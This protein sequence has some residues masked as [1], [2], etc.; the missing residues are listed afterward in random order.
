[1]YATRP[2]A[3]WIRTGS[4]PRKKRIPSG[5]RT[6]TEATKVRL[7]AVAYLPGTN[8]SNPIPSS[9]E[10]GLSQEVTRRGREARLSARVCGPWEVVRSAET[11]IGRRYGAYR[12]QRLCRGKFQYRSASDAVQDSRS[13]CQA[14]LVLAQ[15]VKRSRA[16]SVA[17]ARPAAD[18][19]AP[20]ACVSAWKIDPCRGVIGVQL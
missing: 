13:S 12:R 4:P 14:K 19:N 8:G 16:P 5:T 11:G 18:A 2:G 3:R 17:R 15:S 20:A 7:E 6:V 1:M 9:G 10:S